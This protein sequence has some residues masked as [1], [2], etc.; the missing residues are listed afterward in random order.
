MK[1]LRHIE[2]VSSVQLDGGSLAIGNFDGVHRGHAELICRLRRLA[3]A[4]GGPTIVLTFDPHPVRLLRP[5]QAPPPLTWTNRKAD[6]LAEL[7][8]DF[9]L[10]YPTDPEL[11][12]LS[13]DDF[14]RTIIVDRLR[15]SAMVEG[16]NFRFGRDRT[17][18][19]SQ[20]K[21]LCKQFDISL[22]IVRPIESDESLISS[23]RI[24][25]TI[26]AGDVDTARTMLTQPYRLRGTVTHGAARGGRI[27]FPTA[28][29]EGIDTLIPAHGVYAGRAFVGGS[30]YAA[31]INIGPNPTFG[32]D[33]AKLE[34]HLIDFDED[35][36]GKIVEVDF[37]KRLR[38]IQPFGSV[39]AL[40]DQL[41]L[42]VAAT[43]A[44][45]PESE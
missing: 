16:P 3:Q 44:A 36:Y 31:A 15:I 37:L 4:H 5:Q 2:E 27:G 14:F 34:A 13:P 30:V 33:V 8:V 23:S 11:L 43:R 40:K 6:L 9:L 25:T 19:I 22:E 1:I 7:G 18:D 26:A 39:D 20:L 21:E 24:R 38:D 12:Q 41:Q 42:D 35:L 32:D 29:L 28:N 17:G 45:L 10:A